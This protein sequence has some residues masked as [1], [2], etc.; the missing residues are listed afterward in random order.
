LADL[1]RAE[2][3][4]ETATNELYVGRFARLVE[5][6]THLLDQISGS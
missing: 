5:I 2:Y 6:S 3:E 4:T 1:A